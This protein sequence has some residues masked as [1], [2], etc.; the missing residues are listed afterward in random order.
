LI[1]LIASGCAAAVTANQMKVTLLGTGT[2]YPDSQRF[3]SAILAEAAGKKLL[4]DCGRGVVVRL[5]GAGIN[6]A[7]LDTLF[8]TH[9]H[10]DHVVGIPDLWLTGWFLGRA[11]PLHVLGPDGTRRMAA[12]LSDAFAFDI[13]IR[14]SAEGLCTEGARLDARDIAQGEVYGE[15]SVRVSAFP[16][17]HGSV[18]P[19]FGYRLDYEGHSIVIS[20][21]T[22]FSQ[23]LVKAAAHTDCLIQSAWSPSSNNPTP[24]HQRSIASA[25]DAARVFA[26]VKPR[27]AI[28]YHYKAPDGIEEAIRRGYGGPLVLA[29][30]L[31]VV[32]IGETI[33]WSN[34]SASGTVR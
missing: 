25:E 12:H 32:E 30:D 7:D 27:L 17:D 26:T 9:L 24:P 21:D 16:V 28:V 18:K 31:M 29:R 4:F 14:T 10:S 5:A 34:G 23:S 15:G 2:P 6:P 33:T 1:G 22:R 8:L 13:A 19:A 3:G 11:R 20:G